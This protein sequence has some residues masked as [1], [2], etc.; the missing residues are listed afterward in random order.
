[1]LARFRSLHSAVSGRRV[2]G[3]ERN[4]LFCLDVLHDV[5][6]QPGPAALRRSG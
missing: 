1:V 2:Y 3:I 4:A 6:S 5:Q